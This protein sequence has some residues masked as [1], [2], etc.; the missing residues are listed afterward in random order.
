MPG[1]LYLILS[2][3]LFGLIA[4]GHILRR[5]HAPISPASAHLW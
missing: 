3:G 4:L 5:N 1:R 2:G